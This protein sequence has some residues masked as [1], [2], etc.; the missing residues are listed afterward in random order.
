MYEGTL[1]EDILTFFIADT[2]IW[3]LTTRERTN[4]C[5]SVAEMLTVVFR[6]AT[7]VIQ[8]KSGDNVY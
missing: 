8:T 2:W 7:E 4:V 5:V 3:S 6:F 1:D